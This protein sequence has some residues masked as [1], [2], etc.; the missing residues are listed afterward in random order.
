MLLFR[1][2]GLSAVR[3][4]VLIYPVYNQSIDVVLEGVRSGRG[5]RWW[6][7]VLDPKLLVAEH[8]AADHVIERRHAHEYSRTPQRFR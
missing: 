1:M 4:F 8:P 7:V 6:G 5:R 2:V 3:L